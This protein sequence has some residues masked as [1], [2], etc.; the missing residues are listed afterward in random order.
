LS[1][2][3]NQ[4]PSDNLSAYGKPRSSSVVS[5]AQSTASLEHKKTVAESRKRRDSAVSAAILL[6]QVC[7][8]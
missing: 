5:T 1:L 4:K 2:P 7:L 8:F 3:A 6:K